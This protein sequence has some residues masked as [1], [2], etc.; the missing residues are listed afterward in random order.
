M[1]SIDYNIVRIECSVKNIYIKITL[2]NILYVLKID[3]N[4]LFV[5]KFLDINIKI[6]FYKTR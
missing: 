1:K 2:L 3:I 4:L 6:E 5:K